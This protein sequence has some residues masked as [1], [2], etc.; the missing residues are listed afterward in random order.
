MACAHAH[1][2]LDQHFLFCSI[3]SVSATLNASHV[4][5]DAYAA[6]VVMMLHIAWRQARHCPTKRRP[7]SPPAPTRPAWPGGA[8]AG[9]CC[10]AAWS[11]PPAGMTPR[12]QTR[13]ATTPRHPPPGQAQRSSIVRKRTFCGPRSVSSSDGH[14]IPSA[15]NRGKLA[16]R[17]PSA[18]LLQAHARKSAERIMQTPSRCVCTQAA[19]QS[20]H[21]LR[22]AR[23]R[24]NAHVPSGGRAAAAQRP[25][26][27][28]GGQR[29]RDAAQR[30]LN[31]LARA[32]DP[33]PPKPAADRARRRVGDAQRYDAGEGKRQ[34]VHALARRRRGRASQPHG[35]RHAWPRSSGQWS[36]TSRAWR[37]R[38]GQGVGAKDATR[39]PPCQAAQQRTVA[40][41]LAREARRGRAW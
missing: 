29:Q 8:A 36:K 15:Y 14:D 11:P 40:Q 2:N 3:K 20:A 38:Q 9:R 17:T 12:S 31:G 1:A 27:R 16:S 32:Q 6:S 22:C 25:D 5:P 13:A 10:P 35:R 18:G 21:R 39:A 28:P 34:V 37:M 23:L 30:A 33:V 19:T 4:T 26:D 41:R 24:K 7:A